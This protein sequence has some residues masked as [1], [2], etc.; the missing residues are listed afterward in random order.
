MILH[1]QQ[2]KVSKERSLLAN[3]NQFLLIKSKVRTKNKLALGINNRGIK[4]P[5]QF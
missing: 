1:P 2:D 4:S 3:T 5:K